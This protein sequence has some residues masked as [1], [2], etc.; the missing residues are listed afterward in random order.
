MAEEGGAQDLEAGWTSASAG[1]A[2]RRRPGDPGWAVARPEQ[3]V[4]RPVGRERGEPVGAEVTGGEEAAGK[5]D[6]AWWKTS[7]VDSAAEDPVGR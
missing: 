1:E 7:E 6:P 3:G 4:G 5:N 2:G